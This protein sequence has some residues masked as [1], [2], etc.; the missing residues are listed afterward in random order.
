MLSGVSMGNKNCA[1]CESFRSIEVQIGRYALN[2][3]QVYCNGHTAIGG[4]QCQ[5]HRPAFGSGVAFPAKA[6]IP[7]FHVGL[8]HT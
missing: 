5:L 7:K 3:E 1:R 8:E 4:C 2:L 6:I